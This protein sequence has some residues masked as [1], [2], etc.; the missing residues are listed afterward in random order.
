MAALTDGY[1]EQ[2][3]QLWEQYKHM[4]AKLQPAQ[5]EISATLDKRAGSL[6]RK[7]SDMQRQADACMQQAAEKLARAKKQAKRLPGLAN[8]MRSLVQ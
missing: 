7:L 8:I 6:K 4:H 2:M 3:G 1:Q 5:K